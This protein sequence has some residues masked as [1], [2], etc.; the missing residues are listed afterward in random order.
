[1]KERSFF[2]RGWLIAALVLLF[3]LGLGI[4]LFDLTNLP[5]D[6][7]P[8]R[9]LLSALKARGMFYQTA[10]N[11][12]DW[13][14]QMS[15]QQWKT[16]AEVEPEVFEHIV[17]FTYR[18]TGEQLWVSRVYSSLFWLIGGIFLFL[19]VRDL[20]STDGAVIATAY[21]LFFPYAVI[22]SRSFQP[23]PLM[24]MLIIVFWWMVNRWADLIPDPSPKRRGES[25]AFAILAGLV[26]GFAIFV[27][28]VAA[29]FVIGA[30]LGAV[31]S[32]FNL[33]DLVRKPQVWTMAMLG[34][35]PTAG[36]LF[37][38]I[39]L[40][41][42]LG[43]QFS[44]RFIP[45]L[46]LSPLNY[47]QWATKA[48]MAAGGV[49]IML[50][51]LSPFFVRERRTRFL[52]YGLWIAYILFGLY[53][54]YHVA[55]HDYYHLP[56]I[57][58]VAVSLAPIVDWVLSQLAGLTSKQWMRFAAFIILSYGV[59]ATAW[60]IRNQMKSVD[61]RPQ[62]TM[63]AQIGDTLGHG[64][65]V[66]ALTQDY[67][68]RLAYWGWQDAGIWPNSGDIDYQGVRGGSFDFNKTFNELTKDQFFFLIT[69]FAEL[70]RQ[71]QLKEK[72][73][74]FAVYAQGNGYVIYDLTASV[75]K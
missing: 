8:T 41:G 67:G 29:F 39:V 28:F 1:M 7:H 65:G 73:V 56:F 45:A 23:D 66:V 18:F 27:K 16:K 30:A 12:P 55:T 46:L 21:Y 36:Y 69:D 51:L 75:N 10:P 4:R 57:P 68:S 72:L 25:W 3:G 14:R 50:G 49:A 58:I 6:F 33:R 61:Y 71:P 19:L 63:W 32:R 11:I 31:L 60:D 54:D 48:N 17:A 40:N 37:Y 42:F 59:F 62:A 35:L 15:L 43:Q 2:T 38:G 47:V 9:Q 34:I 20:I 70:N 52:I 26:G 22:A 13:Q 64:G 44:G 53:F 24:V 5:L 74:N